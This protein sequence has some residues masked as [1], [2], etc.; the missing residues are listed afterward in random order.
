MGLQNFAEIKQFS[1]HQPQ[2]STVKIIIM[3][4]LM[5]ILFL[6]RFMGVRFQDMRLYLL[7]LTPET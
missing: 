4:S 1:P 3:G 6:F 7:F 5:F 2:P